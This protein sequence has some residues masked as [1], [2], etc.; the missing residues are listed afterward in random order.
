[1]SIREA[2]AFQWA[3]ECL[4]HGW[5]PCSEWRSG[6]VGTEA[7]IGVLLPKDGGVE[8]L[9][10]NGVKMKFERKGGL[11]TASV[12]FEGERFGRSQEVDSYNPHFPGGIF[13]GSFAYLPESG[14]SW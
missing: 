10:V 13:R 5:S 1:F 14:A 6:E 7:L 4:A 12:R 9:T 11:V 8:M 3:G 2:D